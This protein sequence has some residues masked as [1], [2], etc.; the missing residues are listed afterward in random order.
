[1][2]VLDVYVP[3]AYSRFQFLPPWMTAAPVTIVIMCPAPDLD[4]WRLEQVR[5]CE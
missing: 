5:D 1:M 4:H 2:A 3:R